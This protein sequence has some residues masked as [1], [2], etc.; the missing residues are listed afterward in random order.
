MHVLD[1]YKEVNACSNKRL[2][3]LPSPVSVLLIV[4]CMSFGHLLQSYAR[5]GENNSLTQS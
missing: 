2:V 1:W 3:S 4:L 5:S